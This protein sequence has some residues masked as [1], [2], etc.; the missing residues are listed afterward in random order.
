MRYLFVVLM[1][2]AIGCEDSGVDR[3]TRPRRERRR[4]QDDIVKPV[5][6]DKPVTTDSEVTQAQ[7]IQIHARALA[8][9]EI[10]K[11]IDS[12]EIKTVWQARDKFLEADRKARLTFSD[13][14]KIRLEKDLPIGEDSV[15]PSN[16]SDMFEKLANEFDAAVSK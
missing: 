10:A 4:R 6:D 5:D 1:L 2:C 15:L 13:V 11:S 9:R 12:G 3:E 16:A 14:L 7:R 8:A